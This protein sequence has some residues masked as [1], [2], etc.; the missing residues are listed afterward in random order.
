MNKLKSFDFNE[1]LFDFWQNKG[2]QIA[3]PEVNMHV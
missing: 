2:D 3:F 1:E